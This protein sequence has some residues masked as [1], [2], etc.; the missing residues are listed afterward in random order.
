MENYSTQHHKVHKLIDNISC[1]RR[2]EYEIK[3]SW[4]CID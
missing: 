1:M 2:K 3:E 4:S